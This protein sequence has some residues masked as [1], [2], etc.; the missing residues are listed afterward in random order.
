MRI[1]FL[2]TS[3]ATTNRV[4]DISL[5]LT[6]V[7]FFI[8]VEDWAMVSLRLLAISGLTWAIMSYTMQ[9]I[10]GYSDDKQSVEFHWHIHVIGVVVVI[11]IFAFFCLIYE[12]HLVLLWE[13]SK[14]LHEQTNQI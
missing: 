1:G 9:W 3:R 5:A 2:S 14:E 11:A 7:G 10:Y 12:D 8:V 4:F 13:I 6:L